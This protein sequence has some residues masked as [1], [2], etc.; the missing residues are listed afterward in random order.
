ML[1]LQVITCSK[2]KNNFDLNI[3]KNTTTQKSNVFKNLKT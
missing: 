2:D 1:Y 3:E